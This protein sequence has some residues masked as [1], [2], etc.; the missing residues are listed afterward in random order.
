MKREPKKVSLLEA[1]KLSDRSPEQVLAEVR[2]GNLRQYDGRKFSTIELR[3][4]PPFRG[5][6]RSR[7]MY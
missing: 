7:A 5:G 2:E 6:R 4:L 3:K 1:A